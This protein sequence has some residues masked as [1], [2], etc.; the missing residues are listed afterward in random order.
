MVDALGKRPLVLAVWRTHL[1]VRVHAPAL[2]TTLVVGERRVNAVEAAVLLVR[3]GAAGQ[4]T[5]AG[6]DV[7]VVRRAA[8]HVVGDLQLEAGG[9]FAVSEAVEVDGTARGVDISQRI[10]G[11]RRGHRRAA[12][13]EDATGHRNREYGTGHCDALYRIEQDRSPLL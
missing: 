3:S 8:D 2:G 12:G 1:D 11:M 9:V 13:G 6:E 4:G 10:A 5:S 7:A